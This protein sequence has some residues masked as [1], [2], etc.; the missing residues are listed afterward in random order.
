MKC[1]CGSGKPYEKCCRDDAIVVARYQDVLKEIFEIHVSRWIKESGVQFV[2]KLKEYSDVFKNLSIYYALTDS[3][4]REAF[5]KDRGHL[6][7]SRQREVLEAFFEGKMAKV[8]ILEDLDFLG[9]RGVD[10]ES[11]EKIRVWNIDSQREYIKYDIFMGYIYP[12]EG[13]WVLSPFAYFVPRLYLPHMN[14]KEDIAYNVRILNGFLYDENFDIFYD[15]FEKREY[16][17]KFTFSDYRKFSRISEKAKS[18]FFDKENRAFIIYNMGKVAKFLDRNPVKPG[19]KAH[20]YSVVGTMV[21]YGGDGNFL[22]FIL[23]RN[24]NQVMAVLKLYEGLYDS[25]EV[26]VER[27]KEQIDPQEEFQKQRGQDIEEFYRNLNSV[28]EEDFKFYYNLEERF[29]SIG[30]R[31]VNVE[32]LLKVAE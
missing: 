14:L 13:K 23:S 16:A 21:L 5:L 4:I 3:Q 2:D 12:V 11:G 32:E 27:G 6:L 31:H 9:F 17:I 1:P 25:V 7:T 30:A 19:D 22:A 24:I 29:K 28:S 8:E 10:M 20:I 26:F 18:V 15:G